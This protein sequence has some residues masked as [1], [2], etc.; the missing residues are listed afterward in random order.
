MIREVVAGERSLEVEVP[1]DKMAAADGTPA[2]VRRA[3][4]GLLADKNVDVLVVLGVLGSHD[5]VKRGPLPKPVIAARVLEPQAEGLRPSGASGVKNLVYVTDSGAIQRDLAAVKGLGGVTKLAIAVDPRLLEGIGVLAR[6]L[7]ARAKDAG[8]EA[9]VGSFDAIATLTAGV[10]AVYLVGGDELPRN[11]IA[12]LNAKKLR[13]FSARGAIDVKAG[14]LA[15][16]AGAEDAKQRTRRVAINILRIAG[17]EAAATIAVEYERP[18]AL[19]INETTARLIGWSTPFA[20]LSRADV[21]DEAPAE[22]GGRPLSLAAAVAEALAQNRDLEANRRELEAGA[23][24]RDR[25]LA[26][27]LPKVDLQARA[28]VIDD[29]RA[30]ASFGAQA[31]RTVSGVLSARGLLFSEPALA[32]LSIQG[33]LY[34]VRAAQ[35]ESQKLD[36]ALESAK[37]YLAVLQA[38]VLESVRTQNMKK[39][40]ANLAQAKLRAAVGSAGPTEVLRWESQI[41][42]DQR[43]VLKARSL[44][45]LAQMQVNRFLNRPLEERFTPEDE[46][47]DEEVVLMQPERLAKVIEDEAAFARLRDVLVESGLRASPELAAREEG[48]QAAERAVATTWRQL[49]VPT[50]AFQAEVNYRV[51]EGGP[52]SSPPTLPMMLPPELRFALG[53]ILPPPIDEPT[54]SVAAVLSLP[55]PTDTAAFSDIR[56]AEAELARR[57]LERDATRE[58]LEQRIRS[59][60]L[61]LSASHPGV[62]LTRT[63]AEA[64]QRG[65]SI[66]QD[67]YAAGTIGVLELIDAQNLSLLAELNATAAKYEYISDQLS[68]ERAVGEFQFMKSKEERDESLRRM[69]DVIAK[70]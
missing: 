66:A 5:V 17:G 44:R 52:G 18:E 69:L 68:L 16:L 58:K 41:A 27:L 3:I 25:A 10:D 39:T 64:A 57:Q 54:W 43:E 33:H 21:L 15:A 53:S 67:A 63:S 13:T 34:E 24:E 32:N 8:L 22:A 36:L 50:L 28:V 62:R 6:A 65:L 9:K 11:L 31:Q 23:E 47:K 51:L 56:K 20:V 7:E 4:D 46:A 45:R 29:G 12:E 37:A 35:R 2:G 19:A 42:L 38:R 1:Q 40:R 48:V 70:P 26:L 49:Y 59:A 30:A 60:A 14:A 61:Q 55:L